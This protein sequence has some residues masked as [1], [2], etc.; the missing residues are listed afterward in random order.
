[1]TVLWF[2]CVVQMFEAEEDGALVE[3]ELAVI[4][5]SALGVEDL[6]VAD[7]FRA[8]DTGDRGKIKFGDY[9]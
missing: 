3:D 4:L 5:K 2:A 8:V 6:A 1:M 9:D 7:V